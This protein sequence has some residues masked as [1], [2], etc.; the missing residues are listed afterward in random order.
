MI[1]Q[2]LKRVMF[3]YVCPAIPHAAAHSTQQALLLRSDQRLL[4]NCNT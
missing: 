2:E 4:L 1:L 3:K